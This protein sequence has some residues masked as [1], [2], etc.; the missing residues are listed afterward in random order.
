MT[1]FF[2]EDV[3]QRADV[4][5]TWRKQEHENISLSKK[6][7]RWIIFRLRDN[8]LILR[9]GGGAGKFGR[10]RLFIFIICSAG[11]FE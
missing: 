3:L 9:G 2:V 5:Y 8:H 7:D 4:H 11:K 1:L 10:D 6:M